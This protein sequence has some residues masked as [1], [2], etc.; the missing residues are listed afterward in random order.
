[1]AA[2]MVAVEAVDVEDADD[3]LVLVPSASPHLRPLPADRHPAAPLHG[4]L[5]G[6]DAAQLFSDSEVSDEGELEAAKARAAADSLDQERAQTA[7]EL[8][9]GSLGARPLRLAA[10][11]HALC[12]CCVLRTVYL[13]NECPVCATRVQRGGSKKVGGPHGDASALT[14]G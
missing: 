8:C 13:L 12:E 14:P 11:R 2:S 5:H 9:Q 10:C 1:M 6:T 4:P 7:C 3:E